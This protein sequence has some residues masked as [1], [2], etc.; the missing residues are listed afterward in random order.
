MASRNGGHAAN[1]IRITG[2][3]T[4]GV[5]Y[6]GVHRLVASRSGGHPD[7]ARR[8]TD[9]VTDGVKGVATEVWWPSDTGVSQAAGIKGGASSQ[10]R[11]GGRIFLI[12]KLV[13]YT[14]NLHSTI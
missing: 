2:G 10:A 8:I 14:L 13:V 12:W 7:I 11:E 9:G 4:G 6:A 1:T 5:R 3:V